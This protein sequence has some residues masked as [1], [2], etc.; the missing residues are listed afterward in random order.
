MSAL[1]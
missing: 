1:A